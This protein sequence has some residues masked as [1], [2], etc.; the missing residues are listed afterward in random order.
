MNNSL[1]SCV[2]ACC[3]VFL[4]FLWAAGPV[5]AAAPAAKTALPDVKAAIVMNMNTGRVLYEQ[6]ADTLVP[7]ASLTKVMTLFLVQEA[8]EQG[9]IS[10]L[11]TMKVSHE[12]DRTGGSSMGIVDGQ[13]VA[14]WDLLKGIAVASGNDAC[15]AVAENFPGGLQAFVQRMNERARSLGMHATLFCTPNGLPAKGQVTSARDMLT[16][17]REYLRRFPQAMRLHSM[18]Y[19]WYKNVM[20]RNHNRLL[21]VC[22][23]VDGLKTGYTRASGYNIILTVERDEVRLLLVI[24]GARTFK[25]RQR[26]AR[27]LMDICFAKAEKQRPALARKA[28]VKNIK[29]VWKIRNGSATLGSLAIAL[30]H[31]TTCSEIHQ[32]ARARIPLSKQLITH[33]DG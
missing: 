8:I 12:A 25:E 11:D 6:N 17:A 23:G 32:G 2:T 13:E 20:L 4:G 9:S 3:A 29:V 30:P 18:K 1:G 24:L 7:P 10:Y 19:T 5:F 22:Q 33:S 16:L 27:S 26:M 14:L 15:V 21:G 31:R 28:A